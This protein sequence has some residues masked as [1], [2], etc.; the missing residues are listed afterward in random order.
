MLLLT[1]M[2]GG[3][4]RGS[5]GVSMFGDGGGGPKGKYHIL[6]IGFVDY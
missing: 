6:F 4:Y 2:R 3:D 5:V 1:R